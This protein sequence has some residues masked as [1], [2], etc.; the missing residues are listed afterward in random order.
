ML[1][2]NFNYRLKT[3]SSTY[4][5]GYL[6]CISHYKR[7]YFVGSDIYEMVEFLIDNRFAMIGERFFQQTIGIHICTS[8]EPLLFNSVLYLYDTDF[9][10]GVLKENEKKTT[11]TK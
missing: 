10:Q 11:F 3:G 8:C 5:T 2:W 9:M 6:N 4:Y 7:R 1:L